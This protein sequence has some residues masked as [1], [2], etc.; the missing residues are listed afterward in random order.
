VSRCVTAYIDLSAL[1][2]NYHIVRNLVGHH[3]KI[4]AMIK[5]NAYGHGLLPVAKAFSTMVDTFGVA[6]LN[7]ALALREE[8]I[9]NPII[10]MTGFSSSQELSL[11][12]QYQLSSVV[13][14]ELQLRL[15]EEQ[16]ISAAIDIW[17]K[18]DTGMHRLGFSMQEFQKAFQRLLAI[19]TVKKS[20]KLM[21]HLADAD[22]SDRT[23]TESQFHLFSTL[24]QSLSAE[25]TEKSIRNSAGIL[26]YQNGLDGDIV[27]PGLMLYGASPFADGTGRDFNLKPVMRLSAKLIAINSLKRGDRVGY[28]GIWECPEAMN[29]GVV[30]IGYGDGY[31]RHIQSK[32]PVSIHGVACPIVG[33]VS[34][35]MLSVDLRP[36]PKAMLGNEVLLWGQ[37]LPVERIAASANTIPYELFCR[38]T[39]RVTFHYC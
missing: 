7:E 11:F 6:T 21:T 35:D 1:H 29:V 25:S 37:D 23:F 8:K 27:R 34:M 9:T 2:H 10:V 18:V 3:S 36:Q 16:R 39:S 26:A 14:H 5:A 17:L 32:T 20:I 30:S 31:P 33:R 22:N 12:F 28:G 15:L 4:V 19:P 24:T 38:L 13:Y